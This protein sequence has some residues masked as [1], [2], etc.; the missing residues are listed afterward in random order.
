LTCLVDHCLSQKLGPPRRGSFLPGSPTPGAGPAAAVR[1]SGQQVVYDGVGPAPAGTHGTCAS[2]EGEIVAPARGRG[3]SIEVQGENICVNW[4]AASSSHSSWSDRARAPRPARG[5]PFTIH[6]HTTVASTATRS[7]T[8]RFT[9]MAG[10]AGQ[11]SSSHPAGI[12]VP[13]RRVRPPDIESLWGR[14]SPLQKKEEPKLPRYSDR[15]Q[16]SSTVAF[17]AL[18]AGVR[19]LASVRPRSSSHRSAWP[20]CRRA[21][22]NLA[23]ANART[24]VSDKLRDRGR[25]RW[26]R[27]QGP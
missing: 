3:R 1:Y 4:H 11:T 17:A 15:H 10:G 9:G 2:W 23:R 20:G 26:P 19:D 14:S 13:A 24:P 6:R 5:A 16:L 25:S 7:A 21:S 22:R 8:L 18:R 12:A 27:Q